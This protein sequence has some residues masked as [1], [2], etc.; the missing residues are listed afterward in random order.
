MISKGNK[1]GLRRF[2][3]NLPLRYSACWS[4]FW[5][6]YLRGEFNWCPSCSQ[7]PV[8][9]SLPPAIWIS[10]CHASLVPHHSH[11]QPQA[12]PTT[13]LLQICEGEAPQKSP[14]GLQEPAVLLYIFVEPERTKSHWKFRWQ[15]LLWGRERLLLSYLSSH[16]LTFFLLN[17]TGMCSQT[18]L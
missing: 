6:S 14:E 4:K 8:L 17:K 5:P 1:R 3:W 15:S 13:K 10:L 9:P 12:P 16:S 18:L 11:T 7:I 2:F